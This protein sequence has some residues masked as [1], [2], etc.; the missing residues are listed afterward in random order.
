MDVPFYSNGAE[1][2][3]IMIENDVLYLLNSSGNRNEIR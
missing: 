2:Q 3:G 1:I